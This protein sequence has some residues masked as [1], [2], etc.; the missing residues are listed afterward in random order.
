M[1]N[2]EEK[3]GYKFTEEFGYIPE[4]WDI[5]GFKDTF[6]KY[7][8]NSFTREDMSDTDGFIKNI[9]YGDILVEY[10]AI[11]DCSCEKIP[12]I[13][14]EITKSYKK[15]NNGDIVLADT[16]ED[17]TVGKCIE[18]YNIQDD[19]VI[20]AGMHTMHLRPNFK[21]ASKF[22][23]YFLN[24]NVYHNQLMQYVTGIKVSSISKSDINKTYILKPPFPEQEK[25]AEVLSDIDELIESTQKLIDKKKDLKTATMQKLL[26]P[27]PHWVAK[28]LGEIGIITGGGVDKKINANEISIR[29]VNFLD[30]YHNNFITSK[31]LNHWVTA[32]KDKINQCKV[33]KGDIFF[34]PSSEMR[35]DIAMSA[36]A[37]ENIEN[38][39]YSYH[40]VRFRLKEK[41]DLAFSSY[42][43]NTNYFL[44]QA[45]T[46]CEGSG[47]RYVITLPK[48]RNMKIKY[49]E[50]IGEQKQI[51]R[52]LFDMDAEIEALEKE[53]SKYK[54]L[55]TGM[56]QE[57]LTGKKRLI[58]N[59]NKVEA[60]NVKKMSTPVN[61]KVAN[62]EFKDAII[63]S[64]LVYK[65]GSNQ[66]PLGA[67]R[68]QKLSY[69]FKRHNNL[70][71]DEY[72]KK[73]M[74]PYNPQMKYSG[75]EGIAIRNKYVKEV[76]QRS[77]IASSEISKAKTYFDKYY[78]KDSLLWLE[79]NFRYKSNN[80]LEV[81]ATIDY[82]ILDL[83]AQ[84]KE[85][86]LANIK[87]YINNNAEWKPKLEKP[88]F[89]DSAIIKAI[90]ESKNLLNS[91]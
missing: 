78:S 27:K 29:L 68:R 7:A 74:G 77:L 23:G 2:T 34:T 79:Q 50:D 61:K 86:T 12:Y 81:L 26:T 3:Q 59:P 31:L 52:T 36:V 35:Y 41:W 39:V 71:I 91:H 62:D 13:N 17:E 10:G 21:F 44:S 24:S 1:H 53:L 19:E 54:D 51:A 69:L 15:V 55:K 57:L 28:K 56:M 38:A 16:A 40:I 37:V 87:E 22:L 46:I 65:F 88:F 33:I 6:T 32:P 60:F 14:R 72:L 64:M 25:I 11:L 67:F 30:V 49:P 89:T 45:E 43:F 83:K 42:I 70:P 82:T 63:I 48:F 5:K 66:Y 76:K 73:A 4:D 8:T 80:E 58:N 47:K 20:L 85:I 18:V 90:Q 84:N 9:H 75:G